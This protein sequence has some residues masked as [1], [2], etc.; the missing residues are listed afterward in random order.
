MR[1]ARLLLFMLLTAALPALAQDSAFEVAECPFEIPTGQTVECGYVTVPEDHFDEANA[2]TL[3]LAVAIFRSPNPDATPVI[4]L[5][6]GP[7]GS[8]LKLSAV[9]FNFTL[10]AYR[11]Q[12]DIILLDQR[13][14]G[15]SEPVLGCPEALESSLEFLQERQSIEAQQDLIQEIILDCRADFEA[16]GINV[17]V[18][19]STQNA[20]DVDALRAAL[21]Y[22]Q[23]TL[24]GTSYGTRLALTV[25]RDYPA[26]VRSAI[27]DAVFPLEV[28]LVEN[29]PVSGNEALES[30]FAACAADERCNT[31]YP[32][33]EQVFVETFERLNETTLP[34]SITLPT[35]GEAVETYLDGY[36]LLSVIFQSLYAAPLIAQV[37]QMI[38]DA[39]AGDVA[40]IEQ[41]Y[42]LLVSQLSDVVS[43]GM[44]YSVHCAEEV[45]YSSAENLAQVYETL[46]YFRGALGVSGVSSERIFDICTAWETVIS[47]E[48]E[49]QAVVS[50]I[51]ALVVSGEFDP[52]T[53]TVWA[54]QVAANLSNSFSYEI[55]SAGHAPTLTDPCAQTITRAFLADPT[56]EPD[57]SCIGSI[58]PV[59]F[60]VRQTSFTL[61]P[62]TSDTFGISGVIPEG[63]QE[64]APGTF[65]ESATSQIALLQQAIPGGA[66]AVTDLLQT[67]L[68]LSAFPEATETREANGLTWALYDLEVTGSPAKL[69]VA[70]GNDTGYLVLLIAPANE[71]ETY[72]NQVYLPAIDALVP[73]E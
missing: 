32:N 46:P 10:G 47:D 27:L 43:F 21:G 24:Y 56:A 2:N 6:G 13:G 18:F 54:Q 72:I 33:L 45:P 50:D 34:I 7:G 58:A 62:F 65:A 4:Y 66:Q 44:L 8:A 9:N 57:A 52:V 36:G 60:A 49:N 26:G 69:A 15:Y 23:V 41:I 59:A 20:A 68:G 25:M 28:S 70:E 22:E 48:I 30:V 71:L 73:A 31:A 17:A 63:W 67:Q 38:Y 1:F 64:L 35:T 55:P 3:R 19:N 40:L 11:E 53:P 37:P 14:T 42:N 39:Q 51:P 16:Q 12:Q 5:E 61:V 29:A